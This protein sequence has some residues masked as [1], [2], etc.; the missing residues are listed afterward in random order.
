MGQYR[1]IDSGLDYD[2]MHSEVL[3]LA[4]AIVEDP[5]VSDDL[6]E[7]AIDAIYWHSD[8]NYHLKDLPE[9]A[10]TILRERAKEDGYDDEEEDD[11][12]TEDA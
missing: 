10:Q 12:D 9:K 3:D 1:K 7:S 11:N 8:W 5:Q 4:Y 2:D 6:Y